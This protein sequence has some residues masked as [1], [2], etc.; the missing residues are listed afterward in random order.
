MR[1][2]ERQRAV[3]ISTA[4]FCLEKTAHAIRP[5]TDADVSALRVLSFIS[6]HVGHDDSC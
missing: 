4:T 1:E 6:T 3:R 5:S 2:R